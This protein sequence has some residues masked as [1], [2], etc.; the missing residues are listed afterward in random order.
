MTTDRT[1]A[2]FARANGYA[3]DSPALIESFAA[4]RAEGIRQARQGHDRRKAMVDALKPSPALVL[5]ALGP[6]LSVE[7]AIEDARRF[8]AFW[9]AMPRWRR[10]RCQGDLARARRQLLVARFFRRHGQRLWQREAA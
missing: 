3:G 2:A 5:A 1:A 6:A 10:E 7:E 8:I 9:R 4:I